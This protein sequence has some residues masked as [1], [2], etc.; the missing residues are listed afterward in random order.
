MNKDLEYDPDTVPVTKTSVDKQFKPPV[1][2]SDEEY[3]RL[4]SAAFGS[5]RQEMDSEEKKGPVGFSSGHED[6]C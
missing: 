6:V 3:E 4:Y 1:P 5:R 2:V